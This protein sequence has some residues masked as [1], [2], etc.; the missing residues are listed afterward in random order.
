M[1]SFSS[2]ATSSTVLPDTCPPAA[3]ALPPP[4][5][6]SRMTW[7]LVSPHGAGGQVDLVPLGG[8]DEGGVDAHDVQQ[9]VGGLGGDDPAHWLAADGQ[10]DVVPIEL[11]VLD[12]GI[13]GHRVGQV[14]LIELFHLG[15]VRA[16]AAE[17]GC[18]LEGAAT[19]AHGEVLGVQHDAGQQG[20]GLGAQDLV[21]LHNVLQQLRDHLRGGGGIGLV[22][23]QGGPLNVGGGS[24]VVVD[25][26]H[27]LQDSSSSA[28]WT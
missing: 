24:A 14:V 10:G 16:G 28:A 13:F 19:G 17:E 7:T 21:G 23:V 2:W 27:R 15:S 20:L 22:I 12:E 25:N 1:A 3:A 6:F 26:G 8:D 11:G 18:R 5:S 9:L 4:P